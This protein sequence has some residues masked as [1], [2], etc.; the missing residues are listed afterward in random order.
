MRPIKFRAWD[1]Q[2]KEMWKNGAMDLRD[3]DWTEDTISIFITLNSGIAGFYSDDG[4]KSGLWEHEVRLSD[5]RIILMQFTGLLDKNGKEIYE[6]DIVRGNGRPSDCVIVPMLGGL[7]VLN[8][9]NFGQEHNELIAL[10]TNDAQTAS[11][12]RESEIL[13]N[14]YENPELLKEPK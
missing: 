6:G 14:L 11:W 2:N 4:G 1:T 9:H 3:G 10:P 13:G 8:I 7:S 12:L 5:D